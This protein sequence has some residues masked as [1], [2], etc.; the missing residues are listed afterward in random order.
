MYY[1]SIDML[2]L[3]TREQ[4]E[5]WLMLNQ[6]TPNLEHALLMGL[7]HEVTVTSDPGNGQVLGFE[8]DLA[9]EMISLE[10]DDGETGESL[11]LK[12][13]TTWADQATVEADKRSF[14]KSQNYTDTEIEQTLN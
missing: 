10:S 4:M 12:F 6:A 7:A 14:F 3:L 1:T 5:R 13:T 9:E 2:K 8:V 11:H